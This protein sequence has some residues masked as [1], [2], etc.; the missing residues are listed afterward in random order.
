MNNEEKKAIAYLRFYINDNEDE[1]FDKNYQLD[2]KVSKE[3]LNLIEKQ[4]KEIEDKKEEIY[5][6]AKT[7]YILGQ[8]EER[9]Q[10][11]KKI[12]KKLEDLTQE[13][14]DTDGIVMNTNEKKILKELIGKEELV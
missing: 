4:Q 5:S 3:I 7:N 10:W 13:E 14:K 11:Y 2:K 1:Y 12:N 8:T 9:S 6:I